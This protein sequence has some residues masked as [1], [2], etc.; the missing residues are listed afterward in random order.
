MSAFSIDCRHRPWPVPTRPWSIFM[1]WHDLLFLHYPVAAS[2]LC[3]LVPPSLELDT[4]DGS[5][6]S[7]SSLSE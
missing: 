5:R 4:F 6:G 1:C 3:P 7:A 2:A